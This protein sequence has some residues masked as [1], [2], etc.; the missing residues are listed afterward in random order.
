MLAQLAHGPLHAMRALEKLTHSAPAAMRRTLLNDAGSAVGFVRF[1]LLSI[2]FIH[3]LSRA[4]GPQSVNASF[5]VACLTLIWVRLYPHH[6]SVPALVVQSSCTVQHCATRAQIT[7]H[8]EALAE[9][10]NLIAATITSGEGAQ[11]FCSGARFD[12]G[13]CKSRN[14]C[15]RMQ[16]SS[17]LALCALLAHVWL[18]A[19]CILPSCCSTVL[20]HIRATSAQHCVQRPTV[21]SHPSRWR[22][23]SKWSL[24]RSS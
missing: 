21:R 16:T 9:A 7:T 19:L 14:R 20:M 3:M 1:S 10:A 6:A 11:C 5:S 17:T 8:A 2:R 22:T 23:C 18:L 13:R 15:C 12:I 4:C 24:P